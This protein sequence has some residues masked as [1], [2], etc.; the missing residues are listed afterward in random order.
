M[1]VSLAALLL[2][3]VFDWILNGTLYLREKAFIPFLP[4][5]CYL[6]ASFLSRFKKNV[7]APRKL[8]AGFGAAAIFLI[9]GVPY[10]RSSKY[11][12]YE[13]YVLLL[14]MILMGAALL[15]GGKIWKRAVSAGLL[16]TMCCSCFLQISL[17]RDELVTEAWME[18][19]KSDDVIEAVKK[20]VEK[21]EGL[22]RT[23]T[24]GS[25][26][27]NKAADNDILIPGQNVTSCYSSVTNP[28]YK[29][30]REEELHL[31]RPT[32]NLLMQELS[33]NPLFLKTM[34]VQ[35]LIAREG[36]GAEAPEGY[37]LI[38][39]INGVRIYEKKDV[40]PVGYVT[41]QVIS[42]E[43]FHNLSWQEKQMALQNCAVAGEGSD[44]TD[45]KE[46]A[47]TMREANLAGSQ[48][49]F[50]IQSDK[51]EKITLPLTGREKGDSLLFV[52]FDVK[53][54]RKSSDVSV[55]VQGEKNKLTAKSAV[56]YNRNTTF[57]YTCTLTKETDGLEVELGKGDYEI[58][59]IRAWYASPREEDMDWWEHAG[60]QLQKDGDSLKGSFHTE[61]EGWMI[62]SIPYDEN[63]EIRIDGK[64]TA[65]QK[66]NEGF[67]GAKVTAGQHEIELIYH[68]PGK[69]AGAAATAAAA[70]LLLLD[71]LLKCKRG[72]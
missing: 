2:F 28:D 16:L 12:A 27:Q 5:V 72:T 17:T 33:N 41:D 61:K 63:F 66:V 43:D 20:A 47:G 57:C 39:T 46:M 21:E 42:E 29:A 8:A 52:S 15:A 50:H 1:A 49:S 55:T 18:E 23:E 45:A 6:T 14:D 56:Y 9:I 67:T 35:Y 24:R 58:S 69:A 38:D 22:Y 70:F 53:N 60:L 51:A 25:A 7:I 54:N 40:L 31:S 10:I 3:P 11:D 37:Q 19:Y 34:G 62:T 59:D 71:R 30:F 13:I 32:R 44:N 48:D 68:A 65:V 4:L 26:E 36:S 64:E